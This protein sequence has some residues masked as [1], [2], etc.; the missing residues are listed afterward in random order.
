MRYEVRIDSRSVGE[1][2]TTEAALAHVREALKLRPDCEPEIID[3]ATGRP[4]AP[5]AS[6]GWR[7]QLAHKVGY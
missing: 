7:E 4:F 2:P 1:F 3:S 6:L 5:A